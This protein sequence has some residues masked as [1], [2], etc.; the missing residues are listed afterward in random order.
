MKT[1]YTVLI[2]TILLILVEKKRD[3]QLKKLLRQ[4]YF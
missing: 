4:R 1:I 2:A 3:K